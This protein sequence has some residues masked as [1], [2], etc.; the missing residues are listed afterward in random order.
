MCIIRIFT[1]NS[2]YTTIVGRISIAACNRYILSEK[3]YLYELWQRKILTTDQYDHGIKALHNWKLH[4]SHS[5]IQILKHNVI[6][7]EITYF[8][9]PIT[10][11]EKDIIIIPSISQSSYGEQSQFFNVIKISDTLYIT[12]HSLISAID[13]STYNELEFQ[14][15]K[16]DQVKGHYVDIDKYN[17]YKITDFT[18]LTKENIEKININLVQRLDN[19]DIKIK[20]ID[21]T[22]TADIKND[23]VSLKVLE[24]FKKGI[25]ENKTYQEQGKIMDEISDNFTKIEKDFNILINANI[26]KKPEDE[27]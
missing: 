17:N 20:K 1:A 13:L 23:I 3:A 2:Y 11:K 27:L 10:S 24:A 9:F 8:Y 18:N 6:T 14:E 25:F 15:L 12:S 5:M 19:I 4:Y 16:Y 7:G 22:S 26:N 21:I